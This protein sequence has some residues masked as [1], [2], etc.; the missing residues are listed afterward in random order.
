MFKVTVLYN[1]PVNPADFEGYYAETHIPIAMRIPG[2][3]R[4]EMTKFMPTPDGEPE[5]YRMAEAWFGSGEDMERALRSAEGQAAV[6]DL[7]NFATGGATLLI[8]GAEEVRPDDFR[9]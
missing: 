7:G 2:V 5:Y 9:G 8:G 6:Q 3:T 1:H 4:W